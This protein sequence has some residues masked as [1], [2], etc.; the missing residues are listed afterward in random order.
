MPPMPVPGLKSDVYRSKHGVAD[1][2]FSP[3]SGA[4]RDQIRS[5]VFGIVE[6]WEL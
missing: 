4:Q 5:I 1:A 3:Q 2:I 6:T